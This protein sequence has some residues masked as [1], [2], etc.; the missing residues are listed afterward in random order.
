MSWLFFLSLNRNILYYLML[1]PQR[2]EKI[3][4][5]LILLCVVAATHVTIREY[6]DRVIT[7]VHIL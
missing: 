6:C 2:N 7:S 4:K 1:R 5:Y 3:Q